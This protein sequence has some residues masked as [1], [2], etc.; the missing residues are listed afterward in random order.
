MLIG[1]MWDLNRWPTI[2]YNCC[3]KSEI[4]IGVVVVNWGSGTSVSFHRSCHLWRVHA[5]GPHVYC[6]VIS[7]LLVRDISIGNRHGSSRGR[8]LPERV[9]PLS[10]SDAPRRAASL[11]VAVGQEKVK[12]LLSARNLLFLPF[13]HPRH[14]YMW[15][16][17]CYIVISQSDY[18][19][20]ELQKKQQLSFF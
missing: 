9:Q 14:T 6:L 7:K 17:L 2:E 3:E 1:T 5:S 11:N 20:R 4:E 12:R 13:A 8:I 15:H 10:L 18:S 19:R 16:V